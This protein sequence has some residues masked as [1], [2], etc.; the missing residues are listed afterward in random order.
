MN[1]ESKL[2]SNKELTIKDIDDAKKNVKE[3]II[4]YI[5][6]H[7]IKNWTMSMDKVNKVLDVV[8]NHTMQADGKIYSVNFTS[9]EKWTDDISRF[10]YANAYDVANNITLPLPKDINVETIDN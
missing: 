5:D 7:T 4:A 1:E 6:K 2:L 3:K 9:P 8:A 10:I